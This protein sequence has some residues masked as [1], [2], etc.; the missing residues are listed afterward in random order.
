MDAQYLLSMVMS[1]INNIKNKIEQ[2]INPLIAGA[3]ISVTRVQA[4]MA[5]MI[6]DMDSSLDSKTFQKRLDDFNQITTAFS[7]LANNVNSKVKQ[8]VRDTMYKSFEHLSNTGV[9]VKAIANEIQE[10]E[11]HM[12]KLQNLAQTQV[13]KMDDEFKELTRLQTISEANRGKHIH[14]LIGSYKE[15]TTKILSVG[16]E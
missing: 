13:K 1:T 10:N 9:N 11:K 5:T 6:E 14:D 7:D 2:E 3:E 15:D 4:K 12:R 8:D 16:K